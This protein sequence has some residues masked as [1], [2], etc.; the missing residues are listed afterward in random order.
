MLKRVYVW[1]FPVRWSHWILASSI[2]VM[3]ITGYYIGNPFIPA[4]SSNQYLM[5]WMRMIHLVAAAF[6]NC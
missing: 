1:E 2:A 6:F 3:S 5:G 4:A